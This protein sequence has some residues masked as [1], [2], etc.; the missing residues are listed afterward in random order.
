MLLNPHE[1]VFDSIVVLIFHLPLFLDASKPFKTRLAASPR[2]NLRNFLL[3]HFSGLRFMKFMA[4]DSSCSESLS[5]G[6]SVKHLEI[7]A[8]AQG[9]ILAN[10]E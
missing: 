3:L 5:N 6:L 4:P 10:A 2:L 1:S 9:T 7:K 8:G